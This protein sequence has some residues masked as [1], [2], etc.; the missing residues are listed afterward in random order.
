[1]IVFLG[2][3]VDEIKRSVAKIKQEADI[4][5]LNDKMKTNEVTTLFYSRHI[6]NEN[7]FR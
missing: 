2:L 4:L 3:C 7:E 1:M 5:L 6:S